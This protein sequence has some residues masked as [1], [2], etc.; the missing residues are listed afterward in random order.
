MLELKRLLA[1]ETDSIPFETSFGMK[2]LSPD[3]LNGECRAVGECRGS[4]DHITLR[5]KLECVFTAVCARCCKPFETRL[6]HSF[7]FPVAER[8]ENDEDDDRFL[9]MQDG[10][11]DTESVCEEQ[12]ILNLPLRFLCREGCKGLCPVCGADLNAGAC[13]CGGKKT[14]PRMEKLKEYFKK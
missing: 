13:S 5:A 14:D 6:E 12:L 9:L 10:A 7:E 3:I 11:L 4:S 8:L 2:D 1:G